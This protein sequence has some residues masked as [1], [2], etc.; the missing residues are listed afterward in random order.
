L[1]VAQMEQVTVSN[2]LGI[3]LGHSFEIRC[4]EMKV[5]LRGRNALENDV[6]FVGHGCLRSDNSGDIE[7]EFIDSRPLPQT[8]VDQWL[9]QFIPGRSP[10]VLEATASDGVQWLLTWHLPTVTWNNK[11]ATI[12]GAAQGMEAIVQATKADD[13]VEVTELHY[14]LALPLPMVMSEENTLGTGARRELIPAFDILGSRISV[15]Q[16]GDPDHTVIRVPFSKELPPP[17][18][19]TWVD[20]ALTFL[21]GWHVRQRVSVRWRKGRTSFRVF[22]SS[23]QDR[24]CMRPVFT[25]EQAAE[26]W[27]AFSRYVEY[28]GTKMCF[29]PPCGLSQRWTELLLVTNA[30]V[31]TSILTLVT[32]IEG[33]VKQMPKQ[34]PPSGA[35]RS[36]SARLALKPQ[37]WKDLEAQG[38]ILTA[39]TAAWQRH[40]NGVA[41][42]E[43]ADYFSPTLLEDKELLVEMATRLVLRLIGYRGPI[44]DRTSKQTASFAW[45]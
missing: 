2:L 12:R 18:A 11:D 16:D 13:P 43:V 25:P 3:V 41:H 20:E 10:F 37:I 39:H 34:C 15:F 44:F 24:T 19:E 32:T 8:K 7:Y 5:I 27:V 1:D 17:S 26:F 40:R 30:T 31:H 14:A 28:C 45:N 33:L 22:R 21:L 36:R 29:N 9:S 35:N 38:V 42:G 23:L 6:V 4:S